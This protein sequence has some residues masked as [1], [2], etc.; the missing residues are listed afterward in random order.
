V[1]I[2]IVAG[3]LTGLK[4]NRSDAFS[5]SC[6]LTYEIVDASRQHN[7]EDEKQAIKGGHRAGET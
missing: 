2:E 4:G 1:K 3:G 7:R 5:T 6:R